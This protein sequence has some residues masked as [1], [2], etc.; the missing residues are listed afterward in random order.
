M[1]KRLRIK[2][3]EMKSW[4]HYWE[5]NGIRSD[6]FVYNFVA[7]FYRRF[8]IKP[9]LN[10]FMKKYFKKNSKVLHAGCGGGEVDMDL[11]D[12]LDIT[13]VDFSQN[14]LRKYRSRHAKKCTIINGDVRALKFKSS[15]FDG[16]YNLGVL[17]HFSEDDI[18]KV[19][20]G[21][22]RVLKANGTLIIFWPPEYGISVLFFK[23]LVFISGE[24]LN[25]KN[26]EFHP[27]EVSR[28]RSRTEAKKIFNDSGFC[29]IEYKYGIRDL[30]T[31][32]VIVA[33]KM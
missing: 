25:I 3:K 13:A 12:Y 4:D 26:V 5:E 6:R 27:V 19:L 18:G 28:L 32:V 7:S 22:H 16:V 9:S 29:V 2:S 30:F 17:E 15:S 31:N 14:A 23:I 33:R 11:Q 24:L 1:Y 8:L 20:E 10:H 21:F